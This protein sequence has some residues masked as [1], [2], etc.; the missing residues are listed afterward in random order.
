MTPLLG[1]SADVKAGAVPFYIYPGFPT[2]TELLDCPEVR[3]I[4]PFA[5]PMGQFFAE[6]HAT[7]QLLHHPW[8]VDQPERAKLF[9]VPLLA[10]TSAVAHSCALPSHNG[11][12]STHR[13]RMMAAASQIDM[14]PTGHGAPSE[15][16]P[17]KR[18]RKA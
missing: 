6:V 12:R 10:K 17:S 1:R 2:V 18:Q 16:P 13:D 5:E 11:R 15:G 3:R 9:Y 14:Y 8:R 4:N 7:L